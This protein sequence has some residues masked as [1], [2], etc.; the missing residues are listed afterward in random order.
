V[1]TLGVVLPFS[2]FP[3]RDFIALAQEAE[4]R[5]YD[6]AWAAEASGADALITLASIA[7][8]TSRLRLA[9]GIVP[10]QTRTP[11]VLAMAATT[12]GH[13]APD[14]IA[15][16]VGVSSSIIV[17]QW[18]GL[19]FRKPLQHMRETVQVLRLALSGERVN[20]E[21]EF[22]RIKNFRLSL[23][24]ASVRIYLGALGPRMLELAGEVADGVLLNWL[25]PE[26]VGASIRHLEAGARRAGRS[27]GNF[28]ISAFVRT[29][30]TDEPAAA[31]QW[32]ARDITGYAIVDSY[33]E[34]FRAS[35]YATEVEAVNA[36][37]K[38]GDRA[39]AVT[40][41][42]PRVLEGLGVIGPAGFC[43]ERVA[44]FAKAG[45]TMPVIMPFSPDAD[46]RPSVLRTIRSFP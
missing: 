42:S 28:E 23:P 18:H 33:A 45:L 12:L 9:T 15:L 11:I 2:A 22:Y 20:F 37:W 8:T 10:I 34:F 30:V 44:Q 41:I 36:A 21:G 5:G 4:T 17:G 25:A 35:G 13:L 29:C 31:R 14:R 1:S 6:T 40:K 43:R 3:G 16:G 38:A 46:P 39:G 26:T 24:A 32:L 19:P 7:S 27:L